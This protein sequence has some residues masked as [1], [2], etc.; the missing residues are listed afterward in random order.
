METTH[1]HGGECLCR[2]G[3]QVS[4]TQQVPSLVTVG[5]TVNRRAKL[6]THLKKSNILIIS[7]IHNMRQ[8]ILSYVLF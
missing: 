6:E 4:C 2:E 5:V 8:E 7:I 1:P 3:S